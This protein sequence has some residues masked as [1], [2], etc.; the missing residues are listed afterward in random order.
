MQRRTLYA[1]S[2]DRNDVREPRFAPYVVET[3]AAHH[4][5]H[6]ACDPQNAVRIV[7]ISTFAVRVDRG[8]LYGHLHRDWGSAF[9]LLDIAVLAPIAIAFYRSDVLCGR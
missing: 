1:R 2:L 4:A 3:D 9:S 6:P 7:T 8:Y 5:R